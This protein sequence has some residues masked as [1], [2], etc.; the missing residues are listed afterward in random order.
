[1]LA[2][3]FICLWVSMLIGFA[4][5]VVLAFKQGAAQVKRMHQIPCHRCDF[6]TND[7]RLKCTVNPMIAWS[8]EAITC[9]DFE[10]KT[11]NSNAARKCQRKK[12]DG[13]S[14]N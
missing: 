12:C 8:E 14:L 3:F 1:M 9:R 11:A 4:C 6:F 7:H 10:P 13:I 5:S 2:I